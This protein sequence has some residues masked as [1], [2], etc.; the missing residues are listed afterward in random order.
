VNCVTVIIAN[1]TRKFFA[2]DPPNLER[3]AHASA[4]HVVFEL[5]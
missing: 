4:G 3:G 1:E 5:A 2:G